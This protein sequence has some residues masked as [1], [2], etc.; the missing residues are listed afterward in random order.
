MSD[1]AKHEWAALVQYH[2]GV[3]L[4][5]AGKLPEARGIFENI[6]RQFPARPEATD[7]ALRRGQCL[8][9]E[10]LLKIDPARKKLATPNLKPEEIAAANQ[11]LNEGYRL[12]GEAAQFFDQQAEQLKQKQPAPESRARMLYE[13][14]WCYRT[15]AEPEI[16]AARAK[17]QQER[18]KKTQEEE[19]KK[20][21]GARPAAVTALPD[22]PLSAAPIQ[23]SEQK[24]RGQ[25]QALIAAFPDLPLSYESRFELAELFGER[26]EHD[27]A[28]KLLTEALDKVL[29][30]TPP[31]VELIEKIR[32]RLGASLVAKKDFKAA[33]TQFDAVAQN[34]KSTLAGQAHYRAGECLFQQGEYAKAAARLAKFRDDGQ[35]QNLPGL[36]DRALLRLGHAYA[37]AG[38]WDQSRQAHEILTGRFAN[39]PWIHEARYGIG[40]AWQNQKQHDNA[41][42][43]YTQVTTGTA[44]EIGARAQLQIGLCRLEQKRYPDAV[45]A[46]LVVP[47]TYDYPELSA[48]ALC[49]AARSLV[50][51][52]QHEQAERLLKR[53]IR[54]HPESK[55][56]QVAKERLEALRKG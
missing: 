29:D 7:A 36:T 30:Q 32:L 40:W 1:P 42:N 35:F 39:S 45:A 46:L 22:V 10:G 43:A 52:K 25:Y 9:E 38:Q 6:T 28:V 19:A 31:P 50:E 3:A 47:F 11:A 26:A 37:H 13:A 2:H 16:A 44:T 20:N 34:P 5:E 23:P 48:L 17:I 41:V 18:L 8:K 24:A 15:L 4:R 49:E 14:A 21:P 54:D 53:V 56:A 55:W 12:V 33:L 51:Q 27:A